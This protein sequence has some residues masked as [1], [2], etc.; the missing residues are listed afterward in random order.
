MLLAYGVGATIGNLVGGTLYDRNP[1]LAQPA[2]LGLL[3][4]TITGTWFAANSTTLTGV[5]VVVIGLFGFA[6]IP[7]MQA[8]VMM[9]AADA[10][11]LAMAVNASGYQ[12]AAACAGLLG[13][14]LAD[15]TAGPR[16][17]YL[18]AAA[19]TMLGLVMTVVSSRGP[20][21]GPNR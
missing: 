12:V 6:I 13:G 2:L 11:R 9:T 17:I 5:A 21:S 18:A 1:R 15:S 16:H 10:P 7:G 4:A 20:V 14:L 19:L 8:R 3:A